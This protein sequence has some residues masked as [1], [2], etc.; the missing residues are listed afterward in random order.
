MFAYG[1]TI[2]EKFNATLYMHVSDSVNTHTGISKLIPHTIQHTQKRGTIIS[3][4]GWMYEENGE[5]VWPEGT[6]VIFLDGYYQSSKFFKSDVKKVLNMGIPSKILLNII[7]LHIRRGDYINLANIHSNLTEEYYV[8][9]LLKFP[10]NYVVYV[11]SDDPEWCKK[12][13]WLN[14]DRFYFINADVEDTIR[15]MSICK[16][17][18]IANSTLSWWGAYLSG[19]DSKVVCPSNWFGQEVSYNTRDMYEHSWIQI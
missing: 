13:R 14:G 9:A 5:F 16:N 19:A 1:Y 18:I 2:A 8:Q 12:Q 17:H 6:D 3:Q 15:T 7:A 10:L 4:K 11:F